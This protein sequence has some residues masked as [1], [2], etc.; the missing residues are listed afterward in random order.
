M[1]LVKIAKNVMFFVHFNC[2][3]A[4]NSRHI[5]KTL[6]IPSLF[7]SE[8]SDVLPKDPRSEDDEGDGEHGSSASC[9]DDDTTVTFD[10]TF[11]SRL[12]CLKFRQISHT[13]LFK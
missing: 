7:S 4:R 13:P 3:T 2:N 10:F 11:C 5:L 9:V 12:Y 6:C 1:S 8:L